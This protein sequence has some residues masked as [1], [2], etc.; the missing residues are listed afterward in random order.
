MDEHI[1]NAVE[2]FTVNTSI[3]TTKTDMNEIKP[4]GGEYIEEV[5]D[6][7][8][9]TLSFNCKLCDCKFNDPNA[10][11]MHTK[12]RRHRL[13]YKRKVQPDL[14]VDFKPTLRQRRAVETRAQRA[15]MQGFTEG[16]HEPIGGVP[17]T[18]NVI[19]TGGGNANEY[20]SYWE[21]QRRRT[22]YEE[23]YDY[24]NWMSSARGFGRL[25][26]MKRNY[27]V[28]VYVIYTFICFNVIFKIINVTATI[29]EIL[30]HHSLA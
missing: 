3:A 1:M 8:G 20:C 7:D 21:E 25:K 28:F 2:S 24:N 23:E 11:E 19:I 13:Q 15:L 4:V 27:I 26:C 17:S 30:Y 10:K 16:P 18:R 22:P 9:R 6:K 14:I 29:W 5:K 12:G